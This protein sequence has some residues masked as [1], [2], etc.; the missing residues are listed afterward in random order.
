MSCSSSNSI[1]KKWPEDIITPEEY[2]LKYV[3]KS[4]KDTFVTSKNIQSLH[5]NGFAMFGVK[6]SGYYYFQKKY[7]E[8]Y[9]IIEGS[10]D[11]LVF[12]RNITSIAEVM[13]YDKKSIHKAILENGRMKVQFYKNGDFGNFGQYNTD[14]SNLESFFS[15]DVI[16]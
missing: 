3:N 4:K 6:D 11:D 10:I 16:K 1:E 2:F 15:V 14:L 12:M 5:C 13:E 9:A 7:S 8:K